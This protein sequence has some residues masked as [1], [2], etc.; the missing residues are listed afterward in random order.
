VGDDATKR[1]HVCLRFGIRFGMVKLLG[2][3]SAVALI[4]PA[5]LVGAALARALGLRTRGRS[6]VRT[7][8]RR[9]P[10]AG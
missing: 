8:G 2:V 3:P 10:A 1:G 6:G 4:L 5:L 9:A 7:G